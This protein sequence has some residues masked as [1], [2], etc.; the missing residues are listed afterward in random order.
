MILDVPDVLLELKNLVD[1]VLILDSVVYPLF[2]DNHLKE[3]R[4]CSRDR[5]RHIS[6]V[7]RV[8]G[9]PLGSNS[10]FF[11]PWPAES[12]YNCAVDQEGIQHGRNYTPR[13]TC[14]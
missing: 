5:A 10:K 4:E 2:L 14:R 7:L 9:A 6:E 1:T 12:T 8:F 13:E 3:L 11:Y